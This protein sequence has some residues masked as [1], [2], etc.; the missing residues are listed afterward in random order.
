MHNILLHRVI[1]VLKD[2]KAFLEK[3][4]YTRYIAKSA[5]NLSRVPL[6]LLDLLVLKADKVQL[7]HRDLVET[8]EYKYRV[9]VLYPNLKLIN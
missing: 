6:V 7:D 2:L 9:C 1:K 4:L 5:L 3:R 8:Q